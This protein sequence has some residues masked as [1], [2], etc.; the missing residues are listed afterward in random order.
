MIN[1]DA[2]GNSITNV[3]E[4]SDDD[5]EQYNIT[6]SDSDPD[7]DNT[8]DNRGDDNQVDG[9]GGNID[10]DGDGIPDIYDTDDDGDGILDVND[11]DDDGDG[12]PDAQD[13]DNDEDDEDP[14]TFPLSQIYDLALDKALNTTAT[15]LP[16]YPGDSVTYTHTVM[17]QGTVPASNI[18][19]TDT[20][21]S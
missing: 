1:L 6:D 11:E 10:T 12:I 18:E 16:V 21:P 19:L 17:N 15:L 3:S 5:S 20:F 2:Y 14:A 4:I 9:N 7:A 13:S 8:N